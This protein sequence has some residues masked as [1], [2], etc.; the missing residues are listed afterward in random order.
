MSQV[1]DFQAVLA[2]RRPARRLSN[3]QMLAA[4]LTRALSDL[5]NERLCEA[6]ARAERSIGRGLSAEEAKRRAL[7]WARSA[8]PISNEF[9][10]GAQ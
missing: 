4:N 6:I 2:T 7:A 8:L 1:I 5:P 9:R 3:E 10:R